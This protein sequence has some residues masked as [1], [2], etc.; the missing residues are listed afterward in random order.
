MKKSLFL[1]LSLLFL[2]PVLNV[3]AA[4]ITRADAS[5]TNSATVGKEFS[6]SFYVSY[7][8]VQK[9]T[10]D[11]LG[12]AGVAFELIFDDS[13]LAITDVSS[14]DFDTEIGKENGRYYVV[15]TVK[16]S[17]PFKNKCVD[18]VLFCA[19]YLTT[20]TFYVKDTD[21][22]SMDIQMGETSVVLFK[23][24]SDYLES[25]AVVITSLG[26]KK[27]TINITKSEELISEEP[28]SI[29][30]DSK[31][32][33]VIS[34]AETKVSNAKVNSNVSKNSTTTHSVASANN[35]LSS[36]E[37]KDNK[38]NFNKEQLEYK[39]YVDKKVNTL[40][41]K[42]TPE[43][44][45]SEINIIGEDDLKANDYKVLIEV[46]AKDGS[47]K[48]YTINVGYDEENKVTDDTYPTKF[49]LSKNTMKII[50][51]L[52]IVTALVSIIFFVISYKKNKKLD[53]MLDD[54][55]KF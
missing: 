1:I 42:A 48:T 55:D 38:I 47:K 39:I 10:I 53:K 16:D 36:L 44:L 52:L 4:S 27:R 12:V 8:G 31:P 33:N 54:F 50:T 6:L 21:K 37:I 41:I 18:E 40:D 49:K 20:I 35:N 43:D 11:T 3:R 23:V 15:S 24:G 19:D 34:K 46:T 13:V 28:S 51:A 32:K 26:D 9:G 22:A 17:D 5:G 29:V 2:V 7:S 25:D 14:S 45:E 30:S